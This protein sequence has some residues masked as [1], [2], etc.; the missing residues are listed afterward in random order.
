MCKYIININKNDTYAI[1]K[2]A[3]FCPAENSYYFINIVT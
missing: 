1:N 3:A 2:V